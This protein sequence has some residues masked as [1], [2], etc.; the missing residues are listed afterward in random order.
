MFTLTVYFFEIIKF[1]FAVCFCDA[2][3]SW[4]LGLQDPASPV[5]EGMIFFHNYLVFF[6]V[7]IGSLVLWLLYITI[8]YFNT[9]VNVNKSQIFTPSSI[10]E[11]VWKAISAAG[12][13]V[14]ASFCN[15]K[16]ETHCLSEGFDKL[17]SLGDV[18]LFQNFLTQSYSFVSGFTISMEFLIYVL[19]VVILFL[20]YLL[21]GY[22]SYNKK[23]LE[24]FLSFQKF[25]CGNQEKIFVVTIALAFILTLNT[26]SLCEAIIGFMV[27]AYGF[28]LTFVAY[29]LDFPAVPVYLVLMVVAKLC[30]NTFAWNYV[31]IGCLIYYAY[32]V[33]IMLFPKLE[34]DNLVAKFK[35]AQVHLAHHMVTELLYFHVLE[36]FILLYW[37]FRWA[38]PVLFNEMFGAYEY[39]FGGFIYYGFLSCI[40][41]K[42]LAMNLFNP[43]TK[44]QLQFL[45]FC[46]ACATGLIAYDVRDMGMEERALSSTRDP[47]NTPDSFRRQY[48]Y[49]GW[50]STTAV[51]TEVGKAWREVYNT[52]PPLIPG[53]TQINTCEAIRIMQ[54]ET[55]PTLVKRIEFHLPRAQP[56]TSGITKS[57]LL[58]II[59][60]ALEEDAK[61]SSSTENGEK[62]AGSPVT[63]PRLSKAELLDIIA[64]LE[65]DTE[66]PSKVSPAFE[67]KKK[68]TPLVKPSISLE[69]DAR[70]LK[71]SPMDNSPPEEE[72]SFSQKIYKRIIKQ[73]M[74]NVSEKQKPKP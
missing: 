4:Q 17:F 48:E 28:A 40:I 10:L 20:L 24:L 35:E 54:E 16:N 18:N 38:F 36:Q 19:F 7:L 37:G 33:V 73:A 27:L 6:F 50:T 2:A 23:T 34:L 46:A 3:K 58:K 29:K 68:G 56:A 74:E 61:I 72:L 8:A 62:L 60:S 59:A 52:T 22:R 11:L 1:F 14:M 15:L 57:E 13:L 39:L 41:A 51:G 53:S 44:R 12:L 69:Q 55:N 67:G 70:K 47:A 45:G 30:S 64:S 31:F 71:A 43:L 9:A 25:C 5:F 32:N 21:G 49:Y 63:K 66:T 42:M 26:L 65:E